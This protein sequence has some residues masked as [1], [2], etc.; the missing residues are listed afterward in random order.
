MLFLQ[1]GKDFGAR[2][3][4]EASKLEAHSLRPVDPL[5]PTNRSRAFKHSQWPRSEL[6]KIFDAA[7]RIE[8]SIPRQGKAAPPDGDF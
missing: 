5:D 1:E 7:L 8:S 6:Q 2:I 3:L 4:G